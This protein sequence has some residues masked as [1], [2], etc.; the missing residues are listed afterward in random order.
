MQTWIYPSNMP[1]REYQRQIVFNCLFKNTLVCLPTGL[2]KTFIAAVVMYNFLR[3]YPSGKVVFMA[4]TKPLVMQQIEAVTNI[5]GLPA[6]QCCELTGAVNAGKRDEKWKLHRAFFVT[7]QAMQSDLGKGICPVDRIVCVVMDEA[8]KASGKHAY[9][10]VLDDLCARSTSFRVVALSA[11]PGS[12]MKKIEMV[13]R[14]L[15]VAHVEV[16]DDQDPVVAQHLHSRKQE[17]IVVGL[18]ERTEQIKRLFHTLIARPVRR[19]NAHGL[20]KANSS[21]VT[22]FM[23][24]TAMKTFQH[25]PPEGLEKS[26]FA[27]CMGDFG[28]LQSLLYCYDALHQYGSVQVLSHLQSKFLNEKEK[29]T[30][31]AKREIRDDPAFAQ[32]L[33]LLQECGGDQHPK[34]FALIRVVR[35]HFEKVALEP[36]VDVGSTGSRVIIF[37][38]NRESVGEIYVELQKLAPLIKVLPRLASRRSIRAI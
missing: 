6:A 8:H 20:I 18:S 19:L 23:V 26:G 25:N 4:P 33:E 30:T 16:R 29:A 1:D 17:V 28:A 10:R 32:M 7:P 37:A 34:L 11:T 36:P 2:G 9:V 38:S 13:V 35:E 12:D 14:N 21:S 3:W 15:R 5:M 24:I 27:Q 31:Q 22:K